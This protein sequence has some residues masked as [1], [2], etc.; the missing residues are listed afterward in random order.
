MRKE[1]VEEWESILDLDF[2]KSCVFIDEAGFNLHIQQGYGRL[3]M[4]MPAK[5][6][7]H[8]EKVLHSVY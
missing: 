3:V 2:I 8:T 6:N 1:K 4:G 7:V 5:G